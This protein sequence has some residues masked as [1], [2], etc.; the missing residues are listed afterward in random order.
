MKQKSGRK[1]KPR[2]GE[3]PA[4]MAAATVAAGTGTGTRG[5][6]QQS[7]SALDATGALSTARNGTMATGLGPSKAAAAVAAAG[8]GGGRSSWGNGV[9]GGAGGIDSSFANGG[10]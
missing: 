1:R 10:R 4:A 5:G 9:E 3:D 6:S 2:E 7:A 8:R